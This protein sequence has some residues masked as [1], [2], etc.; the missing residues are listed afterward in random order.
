MSCETAVSGKTRSSDDDGAPKVVAVIDIG[1]T[2]VRMAIA[3]LGPDRPVRTLETL[4]QAVNL[5]KDTFSCGA[6]EP[7]TTEDCV[8]VLQRYRRKLD[9]YGIGGRGQVHVVATSAVR[10]A[11]NRFAFLNRI[12]VATGFQVEPFDEAAVNRVTFWGVRPLFRSRPELAAAR[13]L[14]VEVGGGSTEVLLFDR[15]DVAFA[16][17][18]RLGSLRLRKT[19][20][21]YHAPLSKVRR[22][23]ESQIQRAVGHLLRHVP[24]D[25]PPTLITL[26]SDMRFAVKRLGGCW[27]A[28][29]LASLDCDS[30]A[31][32][33]EQILGRSVEEVAQEYHLA[34]P[35]AEGVGP[36]LLCFTLLARGL[37]LDRLQVS[38]INMRDGLIKE[39]AL[40]HAWTDDFVQQI[41]R[42]ALDFG[43]R[44]GFD[45]AHGRYVAEVS[46]T[47]F[48]TLQPQHGLGSRYEAILYVAA[49]LHDVGYAVAPRSH[50]KHS[51]YLISRGDLFGLSKRDAL[52]AALIARYHRRASPKPFHQGYATL[53]WEDRTNVAQMAA[54]L[55]LADALDRSGSQRIGPLH[56]QVAGGRLVLRVPTADDLSLEQLALEQKAAMFTEIFGMPVLLK[57]APEGLE[58]GA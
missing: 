38:S 32:L 29:G 37:K 22:I 36:T 5:G 35:D 2:A 57:N 7:S 33:T 11:S 18:Y 55:R 56:C 24:R 39:M 20:E 28:A 9:E 3:E 34:F 58:A 45:E 52:L 1:A 42:S 14:V 31:E 15:G 44:L 40:H 48:R 41:I 6:I 13:T 51:M 43:I 50:H 25:P 54:I 17:T 23:M 4:T 12:Y 26:G 8:R 47:L 19:L 46:R 27:D 21:A 49:L 16:H 53:D 10:E 30:F